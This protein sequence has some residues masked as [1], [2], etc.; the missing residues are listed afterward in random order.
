MLLPGL[1]LI[2]IDIDFKTEVR[3]SHFEVEVD[4][5]MF[6]VV[7][8]SKFGHKFVIGKTSIVIGGIFSHGVGI[9]PDLDALIPLDLLKN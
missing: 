5:W 1:Q 3:W 2:F 9:T 6:F 4:K 8:F 7:G